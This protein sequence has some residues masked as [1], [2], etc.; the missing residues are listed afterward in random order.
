MNYV[1]IIVFIYIIISHNFNESM[2]LFGK[3][4]NKL[5]FLWKF[6]SH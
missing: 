1:Q 4:N 5:I 6:A 3:N 2:Y